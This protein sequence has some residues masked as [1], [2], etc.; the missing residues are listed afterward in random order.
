MPI[1]KTSYKGQV[2]IPKEIRRKFKVT[3]GKLVNVYEKDGHIIVDPLPEDPIESACGSL[4]RG[5]SL[6]RSL[7]KQRREDIKREG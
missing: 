6:I 5:P 3:V 1:V 7:L 2:V 4:K